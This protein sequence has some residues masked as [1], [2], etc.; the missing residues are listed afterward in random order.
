MEWEINDL[1]S[2]VAAIMGMMMC[3]NPMMFTG[4]IVVMEG[5]NAA[6]KRRNS[7]TKRQWTKQEDAAL[8]DCL[9]E[10]AVCFDVGQLPQS[11]DLH[12]E[13]EYFFSHTISLSEALA[14][15]YRL[16]PHHNSLILNA[17]D[18]SDSST[19]DFGHWM[20][21]QKYGVPTSPTFNLMKPVNPQR[22]PSND[23]MILDK[24]KIVDF[25]FENVAVK[26]WERERIHEVGLDD[27]ELT[28]GGGTT[29]I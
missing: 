9:V 29:R 20:S 25:G 7:T 10:I 3:W 1:G 11:S 5:K 18:E 8:V 13:L 26:T 6:I 14:P 12:G 23:A 15:R 2:F 17:C 27:L 28:L 24:E 4:T 16:F 19:I 21:F 22:V